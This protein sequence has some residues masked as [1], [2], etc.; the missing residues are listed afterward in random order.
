VETAEGLTG[1]AFTPARPAVGRG[2]ASLT[3]S[4]T[5]KHTVCLCFGG[6]GRECPHLAL[7]IW[8]DS[9]APPV[10]A[11]R[12]EADPKALEASPVA[13]VAGSLSYYGTAMEFP[14]AATDVRRANERL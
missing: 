10:R 6:A 14:L 5:P 1:A 11:R 13:A 12:R 4:I 8:G 2:S 7:A 3:T 9:H